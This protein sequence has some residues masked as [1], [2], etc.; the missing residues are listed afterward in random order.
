M[1]AALSNPFE[2]LNDEGE[3][4]GEEA[5]EAAVVGLWASLPDDIIVQ[6]IKYALEDWTLIAGGTASRGPR[7]LHKLL[8][9]RTLNRAFAQA[10]HT[11]ALCQ[12]P[13]RFRNH[14]E[15][16]VEGV[17]RQAVKAVRNAGPGMTTDMYSCL[18]TIVYFGCTTKSPDNMSGPY[19]KQLEKIGMVLERVLGDEVV[20]TEGEKHGFKSLVTSIFR[21]LDRF[22]VQRYWNKSVP[23]LVDNAW[24]YLEL[25]RNKGSNPDHVYREL[26]PETIASVFDLIKSDALAQANSG[27]Y[28]PSERYQ[29]ERG[30][31]RMCKHWGA[32]NRAHRA[33]AQQVGDSCDFD[34]ASV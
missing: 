4:G 11:M 15:C 34:F 27:R 13:L 30:A 20:L 25:V 29:L 22:Y 26:S 7:S 12:V 16:F 21:Y 19:Y 17:V 5:E 2:V 31:T 32:V 1:K 6:I 8:R 10:F 18:Y 3:E 28:I 33:V 14:A 24:A 23:N 9:L